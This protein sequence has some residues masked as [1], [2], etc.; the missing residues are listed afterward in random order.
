MLRTGSR[1]RA[2]S[3]NETDEG[4]LF[5]A[6]GS[7]HQHFQCF[8]F[9]F[10]LCTLRHA[11]SAL[12][13]CRGANNAGASPDRFLGKADPMKLVNWMVTSLFWGALALVLLDVGVG[14]I[15][16]SYN[17]EGAVVHGFALYE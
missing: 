1:Q 8:I 7:S 16:G 12:F 9:N 11:L 5:P 10:P 6:L 4:Y 3:K 13:F 14:F 15:H 17:T 2:N